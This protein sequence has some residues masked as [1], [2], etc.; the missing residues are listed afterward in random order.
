M[1]SAFSLTFDN[2]STARVMELAEI[3]QVAEA[4]QSLD[5][6][7]AKAAL[8][9]VGGANGLTD[10]YLHKLEILFTDI[11]CPFIELNQ[12]AV[13]DGG[14]DSG[15]MRLLG[16]SRAK[17]RS[18]FPLLG[19][20]VKEK[21]YLP[22]HLPTAEDAAPLEPNHTHFLL[23]PGQSW[24]DESAWITQVADTVSRALPSAT[25][26]INGGSIALNQ[27]IPNSLGSR[28]PVL[29]M[30]GS[31]RA[32]DQLA[33]ALKGGADDHLLERLVESG[34][35]HAVGLNEGVQ[36]IQQT[37]QTVFEAFSPQT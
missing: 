23:V 12:L 33:A 18:K 9:V 2:H 6:A 24:G 3:D 17:T 31:G 36:A 11:I 34:L 30:A 15:I 21:T 13:V 25:L 28:R 22:G 1:K 8:V 14:T 35:I 20:V 29:V 7:A 32:A 27:D 19:V 4:L 26:L 37:L 5:L 10:D 16:R